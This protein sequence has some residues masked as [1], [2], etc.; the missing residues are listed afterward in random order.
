MKRW[1]GNPSENRDSGRVWCCGEGSR[2]VR[3]VGGLWVGWETVGGGD[4]GCKVWW[5][6][7]IW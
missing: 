7:M 6:W 3:G 1:D 2:R 4:E 5:R